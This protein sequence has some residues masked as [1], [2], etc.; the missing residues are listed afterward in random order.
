MLWG[1]V[2]DTNIITADDLTRVDPKMRLNL[3]ANQNK[4]RIKPTVEAMESAVLEYYPIPQ[5]LRKDY[6]GKVNFGYVVVKPVGHDRGS[7][8]N[9]Q[10]WVKASALTKGN[11]ICHNIN[12]DEPWTFY[13]SSNACEVKNFNICD[14]TIHKL[15]LMYDL[16]LI[17]I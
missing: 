11:R 12:S 13:L 17:H 4:L 14:E 3:M 9:T 16:S 8:T 1:E 10:L 2:S 7:W 15:G 6:N 5:T